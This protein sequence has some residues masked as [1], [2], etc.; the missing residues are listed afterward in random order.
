MPQYNPVLLKNILEDEKSIKLEKYLLLSK[1]YFPVFKKL[2]PDIGAYELSV[3]A[4]N[5]LPSFQQIEAKGILQIFQKIAVSIIGDEELH[6][7]KI[8]DNELIKLKHPVRHLSVG[9]PYS[10]ILQTFPL[11][12]PDEVEHAPKKDAELGLK[13]FNSKGGY[14]EERL[15]N[16]QIDRQHINTRYLDND[17][18]VRFVNDKKY[19]TTTTT[20]EV[21]DVL[22]TPYQSG[23]VNFIMRGAIKIDIDVTF[24]VDKPYPVSILKIY[25]KA[26][27]LPNYKG[28]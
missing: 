1:R 20:K 21:C 18:L 7:L 17:A 2:F 10:S 22:S 15:D 9:F 23:W 19:L 13:V 12:S 6:D 26:K 27:I 25:A 28:N 3:I 8:I 14:I 11:I 5:C 4:R 16:G 24:K